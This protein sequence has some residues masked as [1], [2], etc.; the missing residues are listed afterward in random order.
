MREK[1]NK[2]VFRSLSLSRS[3]VDDDISDTSFN[4]LGALVEGFEMK[5]IMV[6][7]LEMKG[8][9]ERNRGKCFWV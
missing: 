4:W 9:G 1:S 8:K 3:L 6:V 2:E 7:S 5:R